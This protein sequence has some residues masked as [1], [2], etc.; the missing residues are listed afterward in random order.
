M[1]DETNVNPNDYSNWDT[2]FDNKMA[3]RN[4]PVVA[5]TPTKTEEPAPVEEVKTDEPAVKEEKVETPTDTSKHKI[6]VSGEE[7][8]LTLEQLKQRAQMGEDY[9][10]KTQ[11]VSDERKKVEAEKAR[12]Q[13]IL[14]EL[15][16]SKINKPAEPPAQQPAPPIVQGDAEEDV[17]L[18]KY[19]VPFEWFNEDHQ[20]QMRSIQRE[21][22]VKSAKDEILSMFRQEQER[23]T[24]QTAQQEL[25]QL[26]HFAQ[27]EPKEV[28]DFAMQAINSVA[29]TDPER[30]IVL[31]SANKKVLSN[32][33]ASMTAEEARTLKE[34]AIASRKAYYAS[35]TKEE[36][37]VMQTE[38]STSGVKI[39]NKLKGSDVRGMDRSAAENEFERYM[40]KK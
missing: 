2:Y 31:Y 38:S 21:L 19:Q 13:E 4:E 27:T 39:E 6:K 29:A 3:A 37:K 10:R 1:S 9:T 24:Q 26:A 14:Q 17:F 20:K 11:A 36:H 18:R 5:E 30:F 8:E 34:H 12:V 25:Q 7:I 35:S 16:A 40:N 32:Q 28:I 22:A 33:A 23:Q 15:E